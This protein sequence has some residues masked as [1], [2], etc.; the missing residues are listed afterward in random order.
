MPF[1]SEKDN[2]ETTKKPVGVSAKKTK[3][4]INQK[5]PGSFYCFFIVYFAAFGRLKCVKWNS[6]SR[7]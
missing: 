2:P 4:L 5:E 3:N 1:Y 7:V 6:S